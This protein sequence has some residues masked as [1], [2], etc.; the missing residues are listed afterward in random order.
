MSKV[1]GYEIVDYKNKDGKQVSG[2]RVHV[3]SEIPSHEG[4]GF[5]AVTEFINGLSVNEVHLGE[6]ITLLYEP[7]RVGGMRCTGILYKDDQKK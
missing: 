3:A 4:S 2:V 5:K 7:N 1:I 6:I